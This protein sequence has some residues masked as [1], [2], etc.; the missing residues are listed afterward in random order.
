MEGI[1]TA[2]QNLRVAS[3]TA[4]RIRAYFEYR[5]QR[6]HDH[7]GDAFIATLP[8]QLHLRVSMVVHES[9]LRRCPLF[10]DADRRLVAALATALSP[11]VYLPSEYVLVAG[12]V[13]RCMYFIASGR[14]QLIVRVVEGDDGGGGAGGGLVGGAQLR[15][16][17][18]GGAGCGGGAG[19]DGV[20]GGMGGGMRIECAERTDFFDELGLFTERRADMSVRCVT[21]TDLYRLERADF[22]RVVADYPRPALLLAENAARHLPPETAAIIAR[23]IYA[24]AGMGGV[25]SW[26]ASGARGGTDGGRGSG[27]TGGSDAE[28]KPSPLPEPASAAGGPHHGESV[29]QLVEM[30]REMQRELH[31]LSAAVA[32]MARALAAQQSPQQ[33]PAGGRAKP[34]GG[35]DAPH[36]H[37]EP[38]HVFTDRV[39]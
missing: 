33:Q 22:E 18:A 31:A 6:H 4:K 16:G 8:R 24:L 39:P 35:D 14:V 15:G 1:T 5:W 26:I 13:S 19:S 9:T 28:A 23:R 11:E 29:T 30:Q 20:G 21:H 7:A 38:Q 3:A 10:A 2:L 12:Y 25:A 37:G 17:G 36:V 27:G 32:E 34:D